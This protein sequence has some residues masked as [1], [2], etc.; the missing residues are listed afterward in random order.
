MNQKIFDTNEACRLVTPNVAN[1]KGDFPF[2]IDMSYSFSTFNIPIPFV[3]YSG[4]SVG[5]KDFKM[6][7]FFWR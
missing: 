5:S 6:Q 4:Y 7:K 2:I 1:T 3:L